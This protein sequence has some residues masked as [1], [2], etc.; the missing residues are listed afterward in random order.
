MPSKM[1][2]VAAADQ[3][4]SHAAQIHNTNARQ[5]GVKKSGSHASTSRNGK[6]YKT[7]LKNSNAGDRIYARR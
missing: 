7:Y 4:G 6:K 1:S 5:G 3:D 2:P